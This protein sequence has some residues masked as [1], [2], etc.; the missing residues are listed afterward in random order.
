MKVNGNKWNKI[1]I[2]KKSIILSEI[3]LHKL[4]HLGTCY[5]FKHTYI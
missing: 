1:I 3:K 5:L 2:Y 4:K